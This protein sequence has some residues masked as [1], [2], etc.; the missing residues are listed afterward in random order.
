MTYCITSRRGTSKLLEVFPN[1][2]DY[3]NK[4]CSK[5]YKIKDRNL[6]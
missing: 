5:Q 3:I 6:K 1:P 4:R 2:F